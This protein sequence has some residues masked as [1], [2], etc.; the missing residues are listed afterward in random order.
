MLQFSNPT[1]T[2]CEKDCHFK[3]VSNRKIKELDSRIAFIMSNQDEEVNN[4][5]DYSDDLSAE[6][7]LLSH[8][9][10]LYEKNDD[11]ENA[12][13][14][15][16]KLRGKRKELQK[17]RNE[18]RE[19]QKNMLTTMT[20]TDD[21]II[22]LYAEKA[23]LL[24]DNITKNEF[25]DSATPLDIGI[26]R[27]INFYHQ[28]AMIGVPEAEIKKKIEEDMKLFQTRNHERVRDIQNGE[29]DSI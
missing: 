25:M 2:I 22:E 29:T 17:V 4:F 23:E 8:E 7:D 19:Y 21:K 1:L 16:K 26:M 10:S 27:N 28:Q 9:L 6:I 3:H 15:I 20:N 18:V 14:I 13:K 11:T 5:Q 24:F 12:L